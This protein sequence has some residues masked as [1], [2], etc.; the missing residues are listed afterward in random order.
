MLSVDLERQ[1]PEMGSFTHIP[2]IVSPMNC[3]I[4]WASH[5][6]KTVVHGNPKQVHHWAVWI[7]ATQPKSLVH[8]HQSIVPV[9]Q[10]EWQAD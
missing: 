9:Q 3:F 7:V 1:Y 10:K 8:Q 6:R 2:Y 5:T 4:T